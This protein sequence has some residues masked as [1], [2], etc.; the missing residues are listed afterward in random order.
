MDSE[1]GGPRNPNSEWAS[2][3]GTWLFYAAALFGVRVVFWA[4]LQSISLI[5]VPFLV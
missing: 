2:Y 3:P 1:G 5:S 4:S